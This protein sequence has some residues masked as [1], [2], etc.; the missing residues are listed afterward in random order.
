MKNEPR[1][2]ASELFL[3]SCFFTKMLVHLSAIA[4]VCSFS[5]N[6]LIW[7]DPVGDS[8]KQQLGKNVDRWH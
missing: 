7:W 8:G 5:V 6:K 4:A 2:F 3:M 1:L